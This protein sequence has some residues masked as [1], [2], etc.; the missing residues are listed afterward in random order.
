[1]DWIQFPFE[2]DAVLHDGPNAPVVRQ[3]WVYTDQP[4]L[5]L[6]Q[7]NVFVNRIWESDEVSDTG[8]GM[9]PKPINNYDQD[10]LEATSRARRRAHVPP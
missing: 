5:P 1:M 6:D 7:L 8:V 2:V 10:A 3:R 9:L 4:F